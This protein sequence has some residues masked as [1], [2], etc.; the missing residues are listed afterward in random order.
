MPFAAAPLVEGP[1]TIDAEWLTGK[2]AWNLTSSP[3][4]IPKSATG[5]QIEPRHLTYTEERNI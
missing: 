1:C 2:A 3:T 4:S 5:L